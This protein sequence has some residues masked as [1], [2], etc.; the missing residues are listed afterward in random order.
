MS[1]HRHVAPEIL[2]VAIVT[3][4]RCGP[5]DA[6]RLVG[7]AVLNFEGNNVGCPPRVK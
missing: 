1:C 4:A 7:M 5:S 6:V 2:C 3:P